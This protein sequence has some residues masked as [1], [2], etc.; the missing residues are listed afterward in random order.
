MARSQ[1]AWGLD[2]GTTSLKAIKLARQGDKVTIE[3]FDVIEHARFLSEPDVDEAAVIAA[4]L[5]RFVEHNAPRREPTFVGVP[6]SQTFARFVKLPP[7]EPKKIP[8]I[9]KFEAIQQIPFPLDQVNWDYQTFQSADSPDVEVGIFAMKR[10]LVAHVLGQFQEIRPIAIAGVQMAPLA[11]FNAVEF[12][13][14]A[15][16]KGTVVLDIGARDTNLIFI[17]RGRLWLRT[18][19][20]GGNNFTEALAKSFRLSFPKA[21][22]LKKTAATSKYAR[23]VYQSMRPVF[24]D[25]VAE[26]QRSIGFYNSSHRDSRLERVIGMGNP[27]KLPNLQ[28]YLAQ[29]LSMEV[30]RLENFK[31]ATADGKI[32]AGLNEQILGLPAAY[33]LALQGLDLAAIDTNLLPMEIARKMLWKL[34]Q[35]WFSA[36]AALVVAGTVAAGL[37][38]VAIDEPAFSKTQQSDPAQANNLLI[39]QM[40]EQKKTYNTIGNT[41][42]N[43]LALV[44][45]FVNLANDRMIWPSVLQDIFSVLPQTDPAHARSLSSPNRHEHEEII[46][47]S[48]TA[49]YSSG[50]EPMPLPDSKADPKAVTTR[51]FAVTITGYTPLFV[52]NKHAARE[53][54]REY[55]RA[56]TEKNKTLKPYFF[57]VRAAPPPYTERIIGAPV[58]GTG[59]P[60]LSDQ[61]W[62]DRSAVGPFSDVFLKDLLG[63]T[64]TRPAGTPGSE[65]PPGPVPPPD[66]AGPAHFGA[67]PDSEALPA[68]VEPGTGAS[69]L[70]DD[71][72]TVQ[73]TV[74]LVPAT[75][76][77]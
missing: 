58:S 50:L 55:L 63:P 23:Q 26:I 30:I 54:I 48:I 19:N 11:V 42:D 22:E 76:G 70:N 31:K 10:E 7:V 47:K 60:G 46:I 68:Y 15:K 40:D 53:L 24:A 3:A 20:I 56:L 16:D 59:T 35:P 21:E 28:K 52:E 17:D 51:G 32:A 2:I 25:L 69:M 13:V 1:V 61:V 43:D 27:F 6:G 29:N 37:R 71:V 12:D 38:T 75:P 65:T 66:A 49:E 5:A 64:A 34:K 77:K 36:A 45:S 8:E 33:G 9:V 57:Y 4:S 39:R 72:F 74:Y 41:Y 44:L 18:I 14:L 62:G 67:R 73:F